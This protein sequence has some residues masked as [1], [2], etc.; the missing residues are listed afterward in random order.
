MIDLRHLVAG[1]PLDEDRPLA[2]LRMRKEFL[3]TR[4][5]GHFVP[6]DG[7]AVDVGDEVVGLD[8]GHGVI[9]LVTGHS[10]QACGR[11]SGLMAW[12]A[13][14]AG[15]ARLLAWMGYPARV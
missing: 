13:C 8:G 9:L 10:P 1:V 5:G 4:P 15:I 14:S 6:F 2:R 3:A 12:T 11:I 7:V